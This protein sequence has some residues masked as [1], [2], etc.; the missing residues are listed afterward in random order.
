MSHQFI[1]VHTFDGKLVG[2]FQ[3]HSYTVSDISK[4]SDIKDRLR[5]ISKSIYDEILRGGSG[6]YDP[7]NNLDAR[8]MLMYIIENI[9]LDNSGIIA[10]LDEQLADIVELGSCPQGRTTRLLQVCECL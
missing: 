5:G 9:E 2:L 6:N 1:D 4:I 8:N 3:D 7:L 10:I